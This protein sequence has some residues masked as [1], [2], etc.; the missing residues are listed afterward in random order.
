MANKSSWFKLAH[1]VILVISL[2]GLIA[3]FF[4]TIYNRP[5]T[6]DFCTGASAGTKSLLA[7]T[8][9]EYMTWTGRYSYNFITGLIA[10]LGPTAYAIYPSL[11]AA[12]WFFALIWMILPIVRHW[13][14]SYSVLV[15]ITW[16]SLFLFLLYRSIPNFFESAVWGAGTVNY[17]LPI[18]FFTLILD[19]LARAWLN[20]L[21]GPFLY[22]P[23]IL[24][25][26]VAGGFSE[27]FI[28]I[29][30]AFYTL[31]IL[32]MLITKKAAT[33]KFFF[34]LL[35]AAL[36]AALVA[37]FIV[38][39]APGNA[40]RQAAS[41][42]KT[43]TPMSKMPL[44]LTRSTLIVF[45]SFLI[46]A[47]INI[48]LICFVPFL[49]AFNLIDT[50]YGG[51]FS[52]TLKQLLEEN[53][54]YLPV[55]Y[56]SI[57]ILILAISAALP[58]TYIQGSEP[59]PRA[60]IVPFFFIIPAMVAIMVIFGAKLKLHLRV[61]PEMRI[62]PFIRVITVLCIVMLIIVFGMTLYQSRII[63]SLQRDYASAWDERDQ[64]LRGLAGS[65]TK[66]IIVENLTNGY[67]QSD[68]TEN[69]RNWVNRCVASYYGFDSVTRK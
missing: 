58:T 67:G 50:D 68:L 66:E 46:N 57:F 16:S 69:P 4:P 19:I 26:L 36:F 20:D 32:G 49:F 21:H 10:K 65:G 18:V 63:T 30:I 8:S 7:F 35:I 11:F 52:L 47:R 3:L 12:I 43:S 25:V 38:W 54:W 6:D 28:F 51:D 33:K 39:R 27:I 9:D 34:R 56:I 14:I 22:I 41:H 44:L 1:I 37:F 24:L 2:L 59:D 15:S 23:L 13:K 53:N 29:Q 31:L 60:M 64:M 42:Q 40:I 45:Y 48:F 61:H 17:T 55:I 5:I 62:R